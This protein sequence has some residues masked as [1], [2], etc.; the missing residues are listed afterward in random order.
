MANTKGRE[1][2]HEQ[3][4]K[5][6]AWQAL[7]DAGRQ[8]TEAR[9]STQGRPVRLGRIRQEDDSGGAVWKVFFLLLFLFS[10]F[11]WCLAPALPLS[12]RERKCASARLCCAVT[13]RVEDDGLH[14]FAF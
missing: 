4:S 2:K 3:T 11:C 14:P 10:I 7:N 5:R 13:G 12:G 6:A 9:P 1:S 8:R